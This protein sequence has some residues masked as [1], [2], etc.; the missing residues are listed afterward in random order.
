MIAGQI[1]ELVRLRIPHCRRQN[2]LITHNLLFDFTLPRTLT[3]AGAEWIAG[4]WL[5]KGMV[6]NIDEGFRPSGQKTPVIAYRADWAKGEYRGYGFA[7][8]HG[9]APNR[10]NP[11]PTRRSTC[12]RS[13]ATTTAPAGRAQAQLA[14]ATR[15]PAR[16]R[17]TR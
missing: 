10:V 9:K 8:V 2:R 7:G 12:S 5:V 3:G 14:S 15:A 6:A 1:P 4:Q 17:R 13:T 16:S 11:E